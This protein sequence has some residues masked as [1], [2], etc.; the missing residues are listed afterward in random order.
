M[1]PCTVA[2][3]KGL[4][5]LYDIFIHADGYIIG[6]GPHLPTIDISLCHIIQNESHY[7]PEI[8]EDPHKHTN[9]I[10]FMVLYVNEPFDIFYNNE[11]VCSLTIPKE[12]NDYIPKNLVACTMF[13]NCSEFLEQWILYHK[14]IGVEHFYLYDNDSSDYEQVER[15][16]KRY[17]DCC[18]LIQ[19]H[20]PYRTKNSSLSGQTTSQNTTLYKYSKHKWI[21]FTDLDEYI[22]SK[23]SSLTDVL[24]QYEKKRSQISSLV[25]PCMWF[26]CSHNVEYDSTNFLQKLVYRKKDANGTKPGSGPKSIVIP[27]NVKVYSIHRCIK[28]LKEISLDPSILRFNHYFCLTNNGKRYKATTTRARVVNKN[29]CNCEIFDEVFDDSL[30]FTQ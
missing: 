24:S 20:F 12:L 28:G 3:S 2:T 8:I 10:R 27:E 7:K 17:S 14:S 5:F 1:K 19:W 11:F 4:T 25:M 29:K 6:I 21:I 26:G 9:I 16:C 30:S 18:T 13:K 22:F 15:I 23:E